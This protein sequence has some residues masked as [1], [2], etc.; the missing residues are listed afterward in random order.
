VKWLASLIALV[1][2][3]GVAYAGFGTFLVEK[4]GAGSVIT[5]CPISTNL[6]D[7]C[8][9]AQPNGTIFNAHFAD[10]KSVIDL[11]IV[12]GS[13]YTNGTYTWTSSGGG[14]TVNASGTITVAS[15]ELGGAARGIPANYTIGTEGTGCTARPAIA[16][17]A[18]AGAGTG[19]SI[20]PTVYQVTPHNAL[21]T[22]IANNWNVPGIDYPVGYD[23]TLTLKDPTVGAN[24]PS[25]AT[26]AGSTV[27]VNSAPCTISGFDFS[28]HHTYLTVAS[29]LGS[30]NQVVIENIHFQCLRGTTTTLDLLHVGS[31]SQNVKIWYNTFDGG[32]TGPGTGLGC[33]TSG[34]NGQNAAIGSVQTGGTIDIEYNYCFG[35]DSKCVEFNGATG[36]AAAV[37]I[38]ESHN[39]WLSFGMSGCS[40]CSHG[41]AEYIYS[42]SANPVWT[43]T[44]Q[45]NFMANQFWTGPT[46]NTSTLAIEADGSTVNSPNVQWNYVLAMGNQSYTG[47][48][49]NNGQVGSGPLYCGTQTDPNVG[50]YTGTPV[51]ANDIVDYSGGFFVANTTSGTCTASGNFTNIQLINAGTGNSCNASTCN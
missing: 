32:Q 7:G 1:F 29:N 5:T 24:L 41:E 45:Y 33:L 8:A 26:V 30:T 39:V 36:S 25:C 35:E 43:Y 34:T 19:G 17:P 44:M 38:I 15:G 31:G 22:S 48:N 9:Q 47:N 28:L 3:M 51:M 46:E 11:N 27:T 10:A 40:G 42:A 14:C 12:G 37:S 18:G 2:L 13:G 23:T 16:I 49:N 4:G 20:T 50:S 6:S 21:T